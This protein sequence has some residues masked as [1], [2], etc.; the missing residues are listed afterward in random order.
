MF[1]T[2]SKPRVLGFPLLG[3]KEHPTPAEL[4][5]LVSNRIT[6]NFLR[7]NVS[8]SRSFCINVIWNGQ[9]GK[10]PFMFFS[11]FTVKV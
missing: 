2:C 10:T 9:S 6:V 11:S 8:V 5:A 7:I 4:L 1:I 3:K